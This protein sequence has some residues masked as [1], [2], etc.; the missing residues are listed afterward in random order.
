ML[1]ILMVVAALQMDAVVPGP[2]PTAWGQPV[3]GLRMAIYPATSGDL[4]STGA[5]FYV[6][7]QNV[8]D[9]VDFLLNLGLMME[10]G[11]AIV[12]YFVQ[13]SV[14]DANGHTRL[15]QQIVG[16]HGL[17]RPGRLDNFVVGLPS[18]STFTLK[19]NLRFYWDVANKKGIGIRLAPGKHRISARLKSRDVEGSSKSLEFLNFWKGSAESNVLE[20]EVSNA[21]TPKGQPERPKP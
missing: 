7:F 18:A 12:P 5:E 4:P 20:F 21:G 3:N 2:A 13:L 14:T 1:L 15:L 6:S 19:V 8:G 16:G 9:S 10:M 11:R 17:V